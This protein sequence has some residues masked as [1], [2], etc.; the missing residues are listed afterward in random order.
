ME[1]VKTEV[2][3]IGQLV[4]EAHEGGVT[5]LNELHLVLVGGGIAD[6]VLA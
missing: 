1:F 2:D 4:A 5:E 3:M 6:V